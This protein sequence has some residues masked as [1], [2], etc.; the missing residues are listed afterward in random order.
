MIRDRW[1]EEGQGRTRKRHILLRG[2][3][4]YEC[5]VVGGSGAVAT[6]A[7]IFDIQGLIMY[8]VL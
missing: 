3:G 4:I 6:R 2:R 7:D 8:K 5:E 1:G